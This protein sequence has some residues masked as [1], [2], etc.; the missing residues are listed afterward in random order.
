M[1]TTRPAT[2]ADAESISALIAPLAEK[3]IAHE[4]SEEG[5][6]T[7]L[8]SVTPDAIR[9]YIAEGFRYHV[10]EESGAVVGVVATR[11]DS[12]L[13]PLFVAERSQGRG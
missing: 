11:D 13:Y 4:F 5:Y 6:Q 3:Y 8:T 1:M 2:L 7:L 12:H 10:A 9:G